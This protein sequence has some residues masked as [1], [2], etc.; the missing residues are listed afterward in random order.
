MKYID[1]LPRRERE[2][3]KRTIAL[4]FVI[5]ILIIFLALLAAWT[6]YINNVNSNLYIA[7]QKHQ[8]VGARLQDYATK[9]EVYREFEQKVTNKG[10]LSESLAQTTMLWS[11]IL[12]N[13]GQAMPEDTHITHFEGSLS[14]LYN[15][16]EDYS[17]NTDHAR[18]NSFIV[19]GY[20]KRY[21]DV[22]RLMINLK[23][24]PYIEDTWLRNISRSQI[25]ASLTGMSFSIETF[26][27]MQKIIQKWEI[28]EKETETIQDEL[29]DILEQ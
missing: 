1:L 29:D 12:Y 7:L 2:I 16:I 20:A 28:E 25:T 9:L 13:L 5:I 22:S 14:G 17:P 27:D 21:I 26:W 3:N 4:N 24:I 18:V 11:D 15:Y 10:E 23:K 6:F 8:E 19:R